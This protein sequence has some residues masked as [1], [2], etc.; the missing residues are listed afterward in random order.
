MSELVYRLEPAQLRRMRTVAVVLA[1]IG[2]AL[3]VAPGWPCRR[4]AAG[5]ADPVRQAPRR[6]WP[7]CDRPG[8]VI[9]TEKGRQANS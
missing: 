5:T 8:L 3:T 6:S 7:S 1:P 4:L 9:V 2:I